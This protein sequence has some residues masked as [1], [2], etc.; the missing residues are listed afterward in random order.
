M[1][2]CEKCPHYH[3]SI[4][5]INCTMSDEKYEGTI[6]SDALYAYN[7]VKQNAAI[8]KDIIHFWR[9]KKRISNMDIVAV[10]EWEGEAL[11]PD[12]LLRDIEVDGNKIPLSCMTEDTEMLLKYWDY[13]KKI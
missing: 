2:Q 12:M 1:I 4:R 13:S 9:C 5:I 7:G 6:Q 8:V 3:L 11:D 10:I